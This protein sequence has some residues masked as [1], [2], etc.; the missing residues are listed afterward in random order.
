MIVRRLDSASAD[1]EE[2]LAALLHFD[3]D[4]DSAIDQ[5]AAASIADVRARGDAALIEA[6]YRF[7]GF[8][9]E[10]AA[11]L[12]ISRGDLDTALST[13]PD[14]QRGALEAAAARILSFHE[15][16]KLA[17]WRI[18]EADGSEFGQ[19]VTAL[20]RVGIYVPGGK[21]AYPSSVLMSA[22]PAKVAGVA[23]IVMVTPTPSGERNAMV[24]AAAAIAGVDRVFA[25]GGAQAIAALA[26]GTAP[27]PGVD[28]IVGPGN[29]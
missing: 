29:G 28:K 23:E 4:T 26:Y 25:I 24:L 8:Q 27:V 10:R 2:A 6:T 1:F 13:L 11:A 19:R 5:A 14:A 16:Q 3:S 22:I 15:H 21:A 18:T 7:D 20:D 9:V 12:E 17:S